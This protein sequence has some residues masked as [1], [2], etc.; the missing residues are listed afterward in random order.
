MIAAKTMGANVVSQKNMRMNLE[1]IRAA[2]STA[3]TL[4]GRKR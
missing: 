1:A 2:M 3:A 4:V